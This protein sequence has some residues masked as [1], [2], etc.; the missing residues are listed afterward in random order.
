MF[1]HFSQNILGLIWWSSHCFLIFITFITNQ[2]KTRSSWHCI[3]AETYL[4]NQSITTCLQNLSHI[5]RASTLRINQEQE[6][7]VP[8]RGFPPTPV[9]PSVQLGEGGA[10]HVN[11]APALLTFDLERMS[12]CPRS[13]CREPCTCPSYFWFWEDELLSNRAE[14]NVKC[15]VYQKQF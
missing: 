15:E 7:S 2:T 6:L 10:D 12:C 3:E 1:V 13:W 5:V 8:V 4:E 14:E 9:C 11:L